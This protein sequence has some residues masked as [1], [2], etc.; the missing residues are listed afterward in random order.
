MKIM[1]QIGIL[2]GICLVGETISAFLPIPFPGTILSM[3]ILFLLLFFRVLKVE[4]IREKADFLLKN[5]AFF[6]IPAGVGILSVMDII[7]DNIFPLICV[8]VVT[9]V[10]TFGASALTVRGVIALQ[11]RFSHSGNADN[12]EGA[13]NE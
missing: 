9:T 3:I 5:M 10:L 13:G 6:L 7:R 12:E 8:V 1:M 11:E 2:F 4:H